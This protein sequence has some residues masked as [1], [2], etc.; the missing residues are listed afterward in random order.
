VCRHRTGS[1][2]PSCR[3]RPSPC[4]RCG[5]WRPDGDL[6]WRRCSTYPESCTRRPPLDGAWAIRRFRHITLPHLR[7]IL[8]FAVITGVIATSAVLHRP[9]VAAS[10]ERQ[11]AGSGTSSTRL[12]ERLDADPPAAVYNSGSRGSTSVRPAWCAMVLFVLSIG[13]RRLPDGSRATASWR[14]GL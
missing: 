13:V 8:L 2:D 11:I 12:P 6:H 9:I 5:A 3:S 7:P 1:I 4:W 10:R 14:V